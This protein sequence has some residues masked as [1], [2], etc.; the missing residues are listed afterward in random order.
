MIR[1]EI[2]IVDQIPRTFKIGGGTETLLWIDRNIFIIKSL[3]QFLK[4]RIVIGS[5]WGLLDDIILVNFSFLNFFH[6]VIRH[7]MRDFRWINKPKRQNT[8]LKKL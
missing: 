6:K 5:I 1:S 7:L 3:K 2:V 8:V 4:M